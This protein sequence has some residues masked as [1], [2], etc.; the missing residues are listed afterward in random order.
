MYVHNRPLVL[1]DPYGL[2]D[3]RT[4]QVI[5]AASAALAVAGGLAVITST[6]PVSMPALLLA[7]GLTAYGEFAYVKAV[8]DLWQ[9]ESG[10]ACPGADRGVAEDVLVTFLG[11]TGGSVGWGMDKAPLGLSAVTA[12]GGVANAA[13]SAAAN[14][15]KL[16]LPLAQEA[17]Y[18]ALST[19]GG[20]LAP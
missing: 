10:G 6:A 9:Y 16:P 12:I 1:V 14:A 19:L 2:W 20:L 4:T 18:G 5:R 7:A 17:G 11:K 13:S 8:R 15:G 3:Q